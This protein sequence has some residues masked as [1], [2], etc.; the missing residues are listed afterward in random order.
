[1]STFE[2]AP[3]TE[4][5]H[6]GEPAYGRGGLDE[7][8]AVKVLILMPLAQQPRFHK[9][10]RQLQAAGAT[11]TA[12]AFERDYF[13]GSGGPVEV[14]SLGR[15]SDERYLRRAGALRRIRGLV[16][17]EGPFDSVYAFGTDLALLGRLAAPAAR[18]IIEI[19]DVREVLVSSGIAA[20]VIQ[21]LD[22]WIVRAAEGVVVTAP[23]YV[24]EYYQGLRGVTPR[25]VLVLENKIDQSTWCSMAAQI[26]EVRRGPAKRPAVEDALTIGYFGVLRCAF[27]WKVLS[28]WAAVD[29]ERRRVLVR[30]HLGAGAP[31]EEEMAAAPGVTYGG[32]YRWPEELPDLYGR[33]DAV[34]AAAPVRT[35][36]VD[37]KAWARANRFY[38]SCCFQRPLLVSEGGGDEPDVMAFGIGM[39]VPF[40][41]PAEAVAALG[42]ITTEQLERWRDG[43]SRLPRSVYV[44]TEAERERLWSLVSGGGEGTP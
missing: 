29:P 7:R 34:C 20:R 39:G 36:H 40:Q 3:M 17:E 31:S 32:P 14:R 2:K 22:A 38:E 13:P 16:R 5:H 33:V 30:G 44:E 27:T 11:V 10:I 18:L 37:N 41:R 4:G 35:D 24:S 28:S 42:S 9:R 26:E 6:P 8:G 1:M 15:A 19:G 23:R 21:W 25:Q 43:F 12:A